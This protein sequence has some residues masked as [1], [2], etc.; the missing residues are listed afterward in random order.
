MVSKEQFDPKLISD[1]YYNRIV[2][3]TIDTLGRKTILLE[4]L[5]DRGESICI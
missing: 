4:T 5:N 1:K 3:E 2:E